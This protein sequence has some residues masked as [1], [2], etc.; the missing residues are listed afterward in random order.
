MPFQDC[1]PYP[2]LRSAKCKPAVN[3]AS[4]FGEVAQQAAGKEM[5][6]GA[7]ICKNKDAMQND[8]EPRARLRR[9]KTPLNPD[10][11][12]FFNEK[13]NIKMEKGAVKT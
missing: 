6:Q 10:P 3:F 5:M 9:Y 2:N 7:E 1:A 11:A 12:S 4:R 8:C 13:Y